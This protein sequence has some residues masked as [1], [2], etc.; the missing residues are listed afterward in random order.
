MC[1]TAYFVNIFGIFSYFST[2]Y[3]LVYLSFFTFIYL[4]YLDF[5][6]LNSHS[7]V[8]DYYEFRLSL[9][10]YLEIQWS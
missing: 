8:G 10:I 7:R 1:F 6:F 2:F 4:E 9:L 3:L 5:F